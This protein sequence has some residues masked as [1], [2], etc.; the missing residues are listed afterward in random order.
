LKHFIQN[1]LEGAYQRPSN[2]RLALD[3][4]ASGSHPER[5]DSH[6]DGDH[7]LAAAAWLERAQDASKDGGVSG[8]YQLASG[9]TSSYPE[10]TG[11]IIP[12]FL[13]LRRVLNEDRYQ[14]RARRAVDFLLRVQLPDGAFPGGEVNENR[15]KPSP[16]NTAQIMHGLQAWASDNGDARC[17]AALRKSGE[18]L[19][20]HQDIDGAW[21]KYFY[22][23][24]ETSYSAHISCWLAEA[25]VF[26]REERF[27]TAALNHLNWTLLHFDS[28]HSWFDL[29][30]FSI[31]DHRARRSVTHTI[32]Y[33]I[34]GVLRTAEVLS[35]GEGQ[36]AATAAAWAALRRLELSRWLPGIL[37][38]RWRGISNYSCLTGNCQLALIWLH[39]YRKSGD[40]RLLNA[41]MK[42]VDLVRASQPMGHPNDGIRGGIAGSNPV[43]G[44]YIPHAFPNWAAKY[45][46]DASLAESHALEHL[47]D[48]RDRPSIP[49]DI[50]TSLPDRYSAAQGKKLKIGLLTTPRS[51][52]FHQFMQASST[53]DFH[54]DL[55]LIDSPTPTPLRRRMRNRLKR[56]YSPVSRSKSSLPGATA[57]TELD[58]AGFC[59]TNDILSTRILVN[60]EEAVRM[61]REH[62]IDLLVYLGGGGI[63]KPSIIGAPTLATLNAHMG[64]LPPYRGMN[65]TEWSLWNNDAVGCTVHLIDRGIDTGDIILISYVEVTG[66]ETV[67]KARERVDEAQIA[68]LSEVLRYT[69]AAGSLPPRSPQSAESGLQYFTMHPALVERLNQRLR[70]T[71][72]LNR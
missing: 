65:V 64:L 61:V 38:Y 53:W 8:R 68:Q 67:A 29:C 59:L 45:F 66:E 16:F 14:E 34:W 46:I 10:T 40:P 4:L 15:T 1:C 18:W 60:S 56:L 9:W 52:K 33:T 28:E 27:L 39:L 30:G 2:L 6:T 44:G 42:V 21:R 72:Q 37:D 7:L 71:A 13:E 31:E 47:V 48:F 55:V 58:V 12:T 26:L 62:K 25:G 54:P 22:G 5:S 17:V 49:D 50:P 41:A 63:L 36:N 32:A 20:D 3:Q 57:V 43:W 35:H 69:L 24:I 70:A 51:K 19:C 23:G 11:Y